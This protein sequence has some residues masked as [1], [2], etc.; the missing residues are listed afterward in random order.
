MRDVER[1]SN[2]ATP[3]EP[4]DG[5]L[6]D[7][8][9]PAAGAASRVPWS[10][11]VVVAP[12]TPQQT[13][14]LQQLL[15]VPEASA[16]TSQNRQ[17]QSQPLE[18]SGGKV[19]RREEAD[20]FK[21]SA[22]ISRPTDSRESVTHDAFLLIAP[23]RALEEFLGRLAAEQI[24]TQQIAA[25]ANQPDLLGFIQ[26][27]PQAIETLYALNRQQNEQA[28]ETREQT[29]PRDGIEGITVTPL[30]RLPTQSLAVT[31]SDDQMQLLQEQAVQLGAQRL[32]EVGRGVADATTAQ[33]K[34]EEES[35]SLLLIVETGQMDEE[36]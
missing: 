2:V 12:R 3:A 26:Q 24:E 8:D 30:G 22:A 35:S 32:R 36:K 31:R 33:S 5:G 17:P 15:Q 7:L 10:Q 23:S 28:S 11:T 6:A 9:L 18:F 1:P 19:T 25:P 29:P 21:D 4:L 20:R 34:A 14:F 16:Q 27:S 13:A